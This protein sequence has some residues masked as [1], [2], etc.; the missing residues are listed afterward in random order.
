MSALVTYAPMDYR[1]ET[2]AVPQITED[3]VLLHVAGCGICAGDLKAYHG[4]VRVWGTSP[5]NRYMEPP[6][7]GGHEFCGEVVQ[8]GSR[9]SGVAPGDR[10]IA[11]QIVPCGECEFCRSGRYWMCRRSAVFGFK[12]YA[13]GGFAEYVRLP[14]QAIL[15]KVPGSFTTEQAALVEPIACGMHALEQAHIAHSDVV[16]IAGMGAIGL[17][18]ANIASCAMPKLVIAVEMKEKRKRLAREFGADVVLDPAQGNVGDAVRALTGGLGCDVYIE[19]SGSPRSASQG[20]DCL[21]NLGRY[22]QMGVLS[23][24]VTADW[25]TIGDGKELSITGSH[26]SARTYDAVIRGIQ[27]GLIRT[28]GLIS[29]TFAL[30]NWQHA[31]E[32]AEKDPEAIK[33]ML[34]PAEGE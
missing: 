12:K 31:F 11:E 25:N 29:H 10:L 20:L 16:V 14:K 19:A 17:A 26:L 33:V 9:V 2:C 23:G 21:R 15:H 22:V 3:E 4:G 30:S 24:E 7:I 28:D 32:T 18:M 1:Y 6:C 27:K 5:E 8:V 13:N 34:T